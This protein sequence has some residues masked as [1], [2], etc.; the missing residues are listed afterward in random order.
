[1]R[2]KLDAQRYEILGWD[3]ILPEPQMWVMWYEMIMQT[4]LFTVMVVI[5]VGIM[6]TILMGVFERTKELGVML[7]IG[8]SP[9]Q[10]IRL[11]LLE[12]LILELCGMAL[13]V[14]SA[15][16][17]VAYFHH[18]GISFRELEAALSQSF[19]STVTYPVIRWYRAL[20]S[21]VMMAVIATAISLY[22][23]WRAG[24][25]DPVKAIYHS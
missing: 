19:V 11:V 12:T 16:M 3:E 15:V 21:V 2:A 20:G 4:I 14:F 8:T 6:N 9:G 1:M 18:A 17:L 5:G 25:M 23:A 10:I 7:A 22:P 24:K 13:G